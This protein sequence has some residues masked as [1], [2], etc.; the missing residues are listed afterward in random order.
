MYHG[1]LIL[2]W[3]KAVK[4][5]TYFP[6]CNHRRFV[7]QLKWLFEVALLTCQEHW[8]TRN[9]D[10]INNIL[11]FLPIFLWLRYFISRLVHVFPVL[12]RIC[13]NFRVLFGW[14]WMTG[15]LKHAS[16]S[17]KERMRRTMSLFLGDRSKNLLFLVFNSSSYLLICDL[18]TKHWGVRAGGGGGST[19]PV[20]SSAKISLFSLVP[21]W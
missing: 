9:L 12:Q 21:F 3:G 15:N 18:F 19:F 17:W 14:P 13:L 8:H 20:I 10:L 4:L 5:M 2:F 16:S 1:G 11:T 7:Y 6:L